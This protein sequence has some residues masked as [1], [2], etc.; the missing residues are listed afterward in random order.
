MNLPILRELESFP[1]YA[2]EIS[3]PIIWILK[4]GAQGKR[5][6]QCMATWDLKVIKKEGEGPWAGV[7]LEVYLLNG[8]AASEQVGM[9]GRNGRASTN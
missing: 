3:Q 2:L 4:I 1:C 7:R 5:E 8:S 6:Y 9:R